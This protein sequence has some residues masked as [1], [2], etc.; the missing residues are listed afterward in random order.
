[1]FYVISIA[2]LLLSLSVHESAHAWMAE[3][4][5]DSTGRDQGRITL[6]PIAHIDPVGTIAFP[7]ILLIIGAPV[8]GWAKPVMVNPYN[9]RNPKQ[10]HMWIAAAGPISNLI[11]AAMGIVLF[12][13]LNLQIV[14]AYNHLPSLFLFQLILI[15]VLL[16]IFNLMPIPPLDGSWILEG[17][18]QGKRPA[19]I[20]ENQTLRPGYFHCRDFIPVF[21]IRS[22]ARLSISS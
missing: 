13:I 20:P 12:W 18:L 4:F 9:L 5:G 14:G 16:A 21:S 22:P 6:N 3:K 19:S 10:A 7:A 1:M 17:L 2:V 11:L 15:N 8:F